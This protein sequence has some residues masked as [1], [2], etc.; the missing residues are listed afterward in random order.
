[1][2]LKQVYTEALFLNSMHNNYPVIHLRVS[3]RSYLSGCNK[4]LPSDDG[5]V[6]TLTATQLL[7]T[8]EKIHSKCQTA[9]IPLD[10]QNQHGGI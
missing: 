1:M 3:I 8:V 4:R 9:V 5:E 7:S 6:A 10:A 2:G